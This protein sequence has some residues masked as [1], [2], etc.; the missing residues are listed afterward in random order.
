MLLK[1]FGIDENS[2]KVMGGI[3]ILMAISMVNGTTKPKMIIL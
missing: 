1:L 2:L 3:L